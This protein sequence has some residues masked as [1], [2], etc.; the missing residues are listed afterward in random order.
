[1]FNASIEDNVNMFQAQQTIV[2]VQDPRSVMQIDDLKNVPVLISVALD[3]TGSALG[4]IYIEE[5]PASLNMTQNYL[6]RASAT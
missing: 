6:I 1:M 5:G 3:D 2:V 4:S